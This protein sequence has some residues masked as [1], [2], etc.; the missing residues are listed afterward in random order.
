MKLPSVP[1]AYMH[2]VSLLRGS[3]TLFPSYNPS[4]INQNVEFYDPICLIDGLTSVP[5]V[6]TVLCAS[7]VLSLTGFQPN[8]IVFPLTE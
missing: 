7:L 6:V 3:C 2:T 1:H 5:T 8:T 4:T